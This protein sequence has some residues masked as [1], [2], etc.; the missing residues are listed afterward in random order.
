M[1]ESLKEITI[2]I[3]ITLF[4]NS[5]L[6]WRGEGKK[7]NRQ[8]RWRGFGT[9][10]VGNKIVSCEPNHNTVA[11]D[12]QKQYKLFPRVIQLRL[13]ACQNASAK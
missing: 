2:E 1:L 8:K 11:F 7:T 10:Q 5:C 13:R 9:L 6:V 3:V 12:E 4:F